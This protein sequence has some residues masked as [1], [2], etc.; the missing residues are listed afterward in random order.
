MK[1]AQGGK[2]PALPTERF[3]MMGISDR[4]HPHCGSRTVCVTVAHHLQ[5]LRGAGCTINDMWD[6][7]LDA[8]VERTRYRPLAAG[9]IGL[10]QAT[11]FLAAQLSLA[12]LLQLNW[13]SQLVGASSLVLVAAYPFMKRVTCW[14]RRRVRRC[15]TVTCAIAVCVCRITQVCCGP[16][17]TYPQIKIMLHLLT[18]S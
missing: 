2:H 5:L 14:V 4:A 11:A 15:V 3:T 18:T 9:R 12:I 8:Q 1:I 17:G 10:P 6:R 13:T 16:W 7:K